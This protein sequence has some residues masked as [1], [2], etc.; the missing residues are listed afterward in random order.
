MHRMSVFTARATYGSQL[1]NLVYRNEYRSAHSHDRAPTRAQTWL[2]T[3]LHIGGRWA[4]LR[5]NRTV[6][7]L[8]WGALDAEDLRYK[9]WRWI[10]VVEKWWR[11]AHLVNFLVFLYDG[12]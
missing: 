6:T 11:T 10:A 4:W 7:A 2:H 8:G 5:F 9:V 12:K 3:V 1:Q